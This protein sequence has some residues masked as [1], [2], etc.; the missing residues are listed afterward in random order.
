M[1]TSEI[2]VRLLKPLRRVLRRGH[3][4][5]Y[6][7]AVARLSVRPGT[8]VTAVDERDRFIA[9]G[10]ADEGPIAIRVLTIRDE[11][12][13]AELL[14]R[15]IRA[16]DELRRRVVPP[17]TDCFRL[18][19]GEGDRLPG[20]VCDVYDAYATLQLDGSAAVAWRDT[21]LDA[22][23]PV[24]EDYKVQG[25]MI[26]TG[27]R[28]QRVVEPAWGAVPPDEV[29][30]QENGLFLSA[31]LH[32]GQKTGLFL[33][34]RPARA[35]VR[36]LAA[37]LRVLDLYAYVGG[38]SAS[39]GLGGAASVVTVDVAPGAIEQAGRTWALNGLPPERQQ[40]VVADVP[41]YLQALASSGHKFDLIV[42]D[43]PSF[44]PNENSKYAALGAYRKLHQACL[45]ILAPE[46]YLLAAS[47][48]SHVDHR[49]FEE[50]LVEAADKARRCLQV[51]ERGGAPAD[52][53]R[54]LAFPEGDYLKVFLTKAVD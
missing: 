29:R 27:R 50:A 28:G 39:A 4:W 53:P 2:S 13:D 25:L 36:Q 32:R 16:A 46:G 3:P 38:F 52:H 14:R 54:L 43:P 42:A 51:L 48:S 45:E 49:D 37:G 33:D 35:M 18:L 22:L 17:H 15:R 8:I 10:W 23:I 12:I 20:V 1:A 9:R 44:A 26:R 41:T 19:H 30:V 6:R 7:D 31:D 34:H 24:L 21:I 11:P 40:R 5:V 47:C